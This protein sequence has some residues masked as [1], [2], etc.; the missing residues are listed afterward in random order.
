LGGYIPPATAK[1]TI[2]QTDA[3]EA[4]YQTLKEGD[5]DIIPLV[6]G[7]H[8]NLG[9]L[10][11]KHP[12]VIEKIPKI[13]FMGGSPYGLEGYPDHIS[14]NISCDPEAF[15][16][17][18]DSGIPLVMLPSDVGRRKAHLDEDYV[19]H[20]KEVNDVGK[21]MYQMYNAY[22]EPG[23]PN[24]RVATNDTC[25]YFALMRP[26]LFQTKRCRVHV[27]TC[28]APGKTTV[29]FCDDGN[30]TLVTDVDRNRFIRL[31]DEKLHKL[32]HIKIDC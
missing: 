22:W 28:D 5:G 3:V 32:N 13:V 10:F 29:T 4:M 30:V 19:N 27:D 21:W 2:S 14:F 8:T 11:T 23:Y 6:L 26:D 25:A 7:P 12:D 20:L 17:V 16:I 24:K 18:L 31:L 1:R 9:V 15:Q